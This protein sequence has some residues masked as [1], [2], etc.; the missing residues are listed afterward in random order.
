MRRA[1]VVEVARDELTATII[2]EDLNIQKEAAIMQNARVAA[3]DTA[4]VLSEENLSNCV[5]LGVMKQ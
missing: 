1:L 2:F 5:I 4:I 3:G